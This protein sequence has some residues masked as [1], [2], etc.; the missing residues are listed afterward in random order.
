MRL[1]GLD[2]GSKRIGVAV[3]DELGSMAHGE[4]FIDNRSPDFV[5]REIQRRI[6]EFGIQKIVVG[7]PKTMKGEEGT[8]AK[9]VRQFIA[10]LE[11]ELEIPVTTW[12]ERLTTA[13]AERS[14]IEQ[15]I[16]RAKRKMK[17]DAF[18]AELMLQAY[19]DAHRDGS[20]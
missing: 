18:A 17:R 6:E 15:D 10:A 12:D 9:G 7:L 4:G 20:S 8:Q 14:M 5:T 13:Q 1:L 2:V 19:M 3:S 11:V 16:S